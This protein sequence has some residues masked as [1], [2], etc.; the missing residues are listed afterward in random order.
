M[1]VGHVTDSKGAVAS[2]LL[3]RVTRRRANSSNG[4]SRRRLTRHNALPP[5]KLERPLNSFH[6]E[7]SGLYSPSRRMAVNH[8]TSRGL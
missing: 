7:L 3:A 1:S 5:C 4:W 2:R 8:S 6:R